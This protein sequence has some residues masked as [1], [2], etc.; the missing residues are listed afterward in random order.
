MV[1]SITILDVYNTQDHKNDIVAEIVPH[2][3]MH[4]YDDVT[5]TI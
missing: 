4:Q 2:L 5:H 3:K 1:S